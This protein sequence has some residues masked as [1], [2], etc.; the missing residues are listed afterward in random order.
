M[1]DFYSQKPKKKIAS[2]ILNWNME[3]FLVP[4]IEMLKP[5]TDKIIFIQCTRPFEPYR[6][7][8]NY[9]TTPDNSEEIVRKRYPEIEIFHYEPEDQDP[10]KM[11]SN[12][13]NFGMSKL[14]NYDLVTKFD[15]DQ[16]FTQED[17][18]TMFSAMQSSSYK[19]YGLNWA[20]QS[21]NY[22]YDFDHGIR[23]EVEK[24][25]LIIDPKY[26]FGPLLWYPFDIKIF[27]EDIMMHHL[28]SFKEWVTKDW[29]DF[30][31]P[32]VYGDYAKDFVAK[33]TPNNEWIKAP[34]EIKD[35]F[36]RYSNHFE[37]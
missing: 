19:N 21:T 12:A 33:Y 25:P 37:L 16:F 9:S 24:D 35:L 29:I 7:E 15:V 13:W 6:I 32:S 11:F 14:E 34:E 20:R 1:N 36:K 31:T 18:K 17:L 22:H 28:R 2:I 4:H 5:H 30:K 10:A 27:D 3:R 8:H 23:N 26:K